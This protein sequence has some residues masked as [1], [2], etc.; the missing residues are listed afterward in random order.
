MPPPPALPPDRGPGWVGDQHGLC[1]SLGR[2]LT[3]NLTPDLETGLGKWTEEMFIP[4]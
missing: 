2:E 4:R 3:A 1:R